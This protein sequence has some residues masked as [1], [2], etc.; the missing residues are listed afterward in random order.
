MSTGH[1]L[2]LN[3]RGASH[4][5][6]PAV[7]VWNL[8]QTL[9]LNDYSQVKL[10][11][12]SKL[13]TAASGTIGVV[14]EE[15]PNDSYDTATKSMGRVIGIIPGGNFQAGPGDN[16]PLDINVGQF[17]T[18]LT[19]KL[20]DVVTNEPINIPPYGNND[21]ALMLEFTD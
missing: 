2:I 18:S 8:P 9:P 6:S 4:R 21:W 12:T 5:P 17:Q 13:L 20:V 1:R 15:L 10:V 11:W 14:I 7:A 16:G 3:T 19:V